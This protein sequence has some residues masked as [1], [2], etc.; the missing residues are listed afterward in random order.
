MER[1]DIVCNIRHPNLAIKKIAN[2]IE[3][4]LQPAP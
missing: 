4:Y 2:L 3:G 1:F